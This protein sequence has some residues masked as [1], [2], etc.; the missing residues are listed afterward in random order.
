MAAAPLDL[1]GNP[2]AKNGLTYYPGLQT[3]A[4]KVVLGNI[5]K[6]TLK[7]DTGEAYLGYGYLKGVWLWRDEPYIR[8]QFLAP[9]SADLPEG[10]IAFTNPFAGDRP[11]LMVTNKIGDMHL[12][13][14][15][16]PV[17]VADSPL[18]SQLFQEN[19]PKGADEFECTRHL[20]VAVQRVQPL[21]DAFR[22]T[23]LVQPFELK[24]LRAISGD[25]QPRSPDQKAA[26]P[27]A[28]PLA[29]PPAAAA[30]A[31][32]TPAVSTSK[33]PAAAPSA[34]AAAPGASAAVAAAPVSAAKRVPSHTPY[35]G[36]PLRE[37]IQVPFEPSR[38]IFDAPPL[39]QVTR[40]G[41]WAAPMYIRAPEDVGALRSLLAS[42]FLMDESTINLAYRSG[43]RLAPLRSI[44]ELKAF[45]I[46]H[47]E[48]AVEV[49]VFGP[50][51]F[52]MPARMLSVAAE[53]F[54]PSAATRAAVVPLPLVAT[55]GTPVGR[56][57]LALPPWQWP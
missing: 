7:T 36:P 45:A 8:V 33:A 43:Q 53:G 28:A 50:V 9:S 2:R 29:A 52:S 42:S 3:A 41:S 23:P 48:W 4:G 16:G 31:G 6:L 35:T 40:R 39:L 19:V 12:S 38:P 57:C 49:V 30:P 11:E 37:Q 55:N 51:P 18:S 22:L 56:H 20:D 13:Q 5:V 14:L 32:M 44:E 1:L 34:S 54:K 17:F 47:D 27:S 25:E 24:D 46:K 21:D 10:A 26:L 15:I